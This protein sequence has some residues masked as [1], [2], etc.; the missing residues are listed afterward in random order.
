MRFWF[1]IAG[2]F[3]L[4]IFSA[5]ISVFLSAFFAHPLRHVISIFVGIFAFMVLSAKPNETS[6]KKLGSKVS[7]YAFF[8][9]ILIFFVLWFPAYFLK[10]VDSN[11]LW[12]FLTFSM[13][14]FFIFVL[15]DRFFTPIWEKIKFFCTKKSGTERNKKSDIRDIE[16]NFKQTK[17]YDPEKFFDSK[18]WFFGLDIKNKPIFY[19]GEKLLHTQITGASGFGK[20]ILLGL[21]ASQAIQKGEATIIFDPKQ[22][23]DEWFPHVCKKASEKVG[24]RYYFID[25]RRGEAQ[26]NL[27]E[28]AT[29]EQIEN[30]LIAGFL[31]EDR[32]DA[33]DYYRGKDRR[34]ARFVGENYQL[35]LTATKISQEYD[36]YFR[37]KEN[38]A[39]S[40]ANQLEE[41]GRVKAVNATHGISLKKIIE[42]GE[43]LYIAGDWQDPKYVK[44]QRMLLDRIV[45]IVSERDNNLEMPK[46][47]CVILDEFSF[48]ISKIFGDSLKVIRDKGL[49]FI[50]AHQSITD[51]T[52]VP[53]NMDAQAFA[54]SVMS[55][56]SLKFMYRAVDFETAKYFSD[57][58]GE[59]LVD[60]E[61][62][63]VEKTLSLTDRVTAEKQIRQTE[64][65]LFDVNTMLLLPPKTGIFY[66][67]GIARVSSVYPIKVE[68]NADSKR[69]ENFDNSK[70]VENINPSNIF[71]FSNLE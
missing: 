71:I 59:I 1:L 35:G 70:D 28:D 30:L 19:N 15:F 27:F 63:Y 2:G 29:P 43:F 41:I 9:F 44:V 50:L 33:A 60:D 23:G 37:S 26:L 20:S 65:N 3:T 39:E 40:F 64:R 49:H 69:V 61:A 6:L 17:E 62:R 13:S 46:Q 24:A 5:E 16:A 47:V 22:S 25:L 54:G 52:N 7:F 38:E 12:L 66:G 10:K 57:F 31:L 53:A 68:K 32:G 8:I 56:C 4:I 18:K 42:N 14:S 55:N 34:M 58:S 48:Q 67:N 45:Q 11:E 21:L 36:Q 51:L